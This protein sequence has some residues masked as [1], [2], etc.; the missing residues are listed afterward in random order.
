M[1]NFKYNNVECWRLFNLKKMFVIIILILCVT[2]VV[3]GNLHWNQKISA[4]G[5]KISSSDRV[6]DKKEVVKE[7][8]PDI[9]PKISGYT[10]NLPENL[11]KKV[12]ES[13]L[14]EKPVKLV[15]YGTSE[16]EGTWSERFQKELKSAYGNVFDLTVISTG[17]K[18]TQDLVSDN[19]YKELDKIAPDVVL[20][21]VPMLKDNGNV[22]IENTIENVNEIISNWK[23]ENKEAVLIIQPPNPLYNAVYYPNEVNQLKEYA[24]NNSLIY[25]DHWGNWPELNDEKMKDFLTT[26]NSGNEKGFEVW[27]NYIIDY[28]VKK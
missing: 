28:F 26:N 22:G 17:D 14:N 23:T 19:S 21:E 4:Q 11:Q 9:N 18:T 13:I 12:N 2:T 16:V 24:K 20:F 1:Y 27:S 10:T 7:D 3:I 6:D 15:I 25:L 5:E 8:N